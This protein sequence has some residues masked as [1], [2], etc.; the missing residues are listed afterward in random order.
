MTIANIVFALINISTAKMK[1][2]QDGLGSPVDCKLVG[3]SHHFH[4]DLNSNKVH[5]GMHM[6][7]DEARP[8]VHMCPDEA[9]PGVH[10]CPNVKVQG[11]KGAMCTSCTNGSSTCTMEYPLKGFGKGSAHL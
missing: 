10:L 11:L 1:R 3:L 8:G 6:C 9:C 4:H 5:P 7:P 2:I